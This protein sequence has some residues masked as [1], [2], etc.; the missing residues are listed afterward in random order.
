M[1]IERKEK[2]GLDFFLL[3]SFDRGLREW[4]PITHTGFDDASYAA[5]EVRI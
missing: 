5:I 2:N 1:W 4:M 3:K